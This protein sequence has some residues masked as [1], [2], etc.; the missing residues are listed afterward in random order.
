MTSKQ[1]MLLIVIVTMVMIFVTGCDAITPSNED[2]PII[3]SGI[4][5]AIEVNAAAE[6]SGKVTEI[7]VEEGHSVGFGEPLLLLENEILD[8]QLEQAIAAVQVAEAQ[9]DSMESGI[10]SAEAA[11]ASARV[12]LEMAKLHFETVLKQ[13]N[14]FEAPLREFVWDGDAPDEF[15]L[16]TWYFNRVEEAQAAEKEIQQAAADLDIERA[17]LEDVLDNISNADFRTAENRLLNAR[18]AFLVAETLLD[19]DVEQNGREAIE[20][21]IQSL[22]DT[23]E[24]E[25][26]SAQKA[27]GSLL[28]DEKTEDVLEARARVEVAYER[29]KI[30]VNNA[31]S[32]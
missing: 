24:A 10:D 29:Y 1:K 14:I 7:F 28:S 30:A 32:Y 21:Y 25:L 6:V 20:D 4:V 3:A 23:A 16:P 26:E 19:K 8:A 31:Y 5:E 18:A 27:Y 22:Y 2:E 9:L 12:G 17:N 11:V 13:A 15:E